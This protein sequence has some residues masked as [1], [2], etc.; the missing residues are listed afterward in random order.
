MKITIVGMGYVGLSNAVMLAEKNNVTVLETNSQKVSDLNS[1]ISPIK[2]SLI[3]KYLKEKTLNLKATTDSLSAYKSSSII[4]I[5]TPT[6]YVDLKSSFDT[7]SIDDV[8]AQIDQLN[9]KGLIV[10]R[11]TVPIGYTDGLQSKYPYRNFA[12]F[13][14]FLREGNSLRDGLNPS[15]IIC[16]SYN[17]K[18]ELFLKLLINSAIKKNINVMTVSPSEAESIKLFANSYLAMRVAYFNELDSYALANSL[19]TKNIIEG[20]SMDP[21]IGQHYNNP[22]FGYGGYCL[23]KDTKQLVSSFNK[24]PQSLVSATILSNKKRKEFLVKEILSK[25]AKS[26]GV[27]KLVMKKGSDNFRES[28]LLHVVEKL[29]RERK[30]FIFEPLIQDKNFNGIE[31]INCFDEFVSRS[32][33]IISNRVDD[34]L[35]AINKVFSRDI[36]KIN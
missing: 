10:V 21:R 32:D 11:S 9:F 25:S 33:L 8:V 35:S 1:K 28:A 34:K 4:V 13:P 29:K 18:G 36:F 6:N 15:R 3:S 17:K 20:V 24:T 12:F 23:P 2:D 30:I 5:C 27:Y 14:E 16:G 7:S 26:I 22:S 19:N 31:V